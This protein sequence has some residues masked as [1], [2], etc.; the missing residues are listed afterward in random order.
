MTLSEE[1]VEMEVKNRKPVYHENMQKLSSTKR[2]KRKKL[3]LR[4]DNDLQDE[5]KLSYFAKCSP[6]F[7]F[8]FFAT[9]TLYRSLF[10]SSPAG[11]RSANIQLVTHSSVPLSTNT[12]CSQHALLLFLMFDENVNCPFRVK[13]QVTPETLGYILPYQ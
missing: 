12:V 4:P 13:Q 11:Q 7:S 2:H 10:L 3:P 8:F 1:Q 6:G 9:V 5:E